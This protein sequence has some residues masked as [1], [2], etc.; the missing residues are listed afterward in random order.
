MSEGELIRSAWDSYF[1]VARAMQPMAELE[2][3]KRL[4]DIYF[5]DEHNALHWASWWDSEDCWLFD[6]SDDERGFDETNAI[7]WMAEIPS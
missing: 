7:G 3:A 5:V 4:V 6:R 2:K 1:N